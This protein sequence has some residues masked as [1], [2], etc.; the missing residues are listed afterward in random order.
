MGIVRI[1]LEY[2]LRVPLRRV[3]DMAVGGYKAQGRLVAA[4]SGATPEVQIEAFVLE[5]L[6]GLLLDEGLPFDL[7][8]AALGS[9]AADI[10]ALAARA[11]AFAVL[12]GRDAF[13]AVVTAYNR[14]ASLAAK[15]AAGEAVS[16]APALFILDA[17]RA[18]YEAVAEAASPLSGAL[19][20]LDIESALAAAARLRPVVDRY[21]DEV[22]VMDQ[23]PAVRANRLAQLVAVSGLLRHIGE[24]SRLAV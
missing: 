20:Q 2:D 3:V 18:L 6:E 15:E 8:E 5:R 17:E 11:R 24:F 21:F 1:A 12:G 10:P 23:D 14:C 7:V 16:V 19:E 4:A 9:D 22:L 13:V